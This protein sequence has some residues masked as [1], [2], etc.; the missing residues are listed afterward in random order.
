M[1]G[2]PR[3]RLTIRER[4]ALLRARPAA[5]LVLVPIRRRL[6]TTD[7]S[8]DHQPRAVTLPAM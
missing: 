6:F 2:A 3:P 8:T 7:Y 4:T 1:M 5:V